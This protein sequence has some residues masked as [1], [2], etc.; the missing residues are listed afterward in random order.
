M[1]REIKE[2][3]NTLPNYLN[4]F[5]QLLCMVTL[6]LDFQCIILY[7]AKMG[8][9]QRKSEKRRLLLTVRYR[10]LIELE[11]AMTIYIQLTA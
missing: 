7:F 5:I 1:A 2:D 4:S 8:A 10:T 9:D 6:W 11:I 3:K